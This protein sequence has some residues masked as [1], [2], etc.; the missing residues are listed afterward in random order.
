MLIQKGRDK[1]RHTQEKKRKTKFIVYLSACYGW[2]S[3]QL[4][5]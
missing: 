2:Y 4:L 5:K 3:S 1:Q